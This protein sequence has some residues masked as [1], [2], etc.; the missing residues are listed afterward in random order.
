MNFNPV[1]MEKHY[2]LLSNKLRICNFC[3][4]GW[5]MLAL[6][7]L[8]GACNLL[9]SK[10]I[11]PEAAGDTLKETFI[12]NPQKIAR[13]EIKRLP[14]GSPAPDFN[15]PDIN[16][17]FLSL[18]D[19]AK[20]KVLVV[21]FTCNHCPT[22]QAYED[23]L[24][25]LTNDYKDKGVAVVAIMPNSTYGLLLEEC[26]YSDLND[27]YEEMK[28]RAE[29]KG[30]NFSY[31]YD[32][33]NQAVSIKYGPATTPHVFVFD[34]DRKLCYTGRLDGSEKPGTANAEDLRM[35]VDELLENK[36]VTNPETNTFGCSI[37]WSW[38]SEWANKVNK[39]WSE[40]PVILEEIDNNGIR[41]LLQN[42][43]GKL[44]LINFWATW[45]APCVIELPELIKLQR[46][47]GNRNFE[48]ITV[49]TDK[50]VNKEEVLKF[51]QEKESALQNYIYNKSDQY[52]LVR[53]VD[54]GWEGALPY[55][56]LV[57]PGGKVISVDQGIADI[58][59]LRKKIV[60][61]PLLG[62][63]Y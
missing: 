29:N 3:R 55:T 60:E 44:R 45:C 30:F 34:K 21:V 5:I 35:A 62:R 28:L 39:E 47:Y 27:S 12:P 48:L 38:K 14:L 6:F 51:L 24:I 53:E 17:T 54:S 40:K 59:E 31:L 18:K 19:F 26:G 20:A 57:E 56:M 58:L 46:M 16:G 42:K 50:I 33:D 36:T 8:L 49:S 1:K 43:T 63:Y 15:L 61:H 37:K 2:F 10:K 41:E 4:V 11:L 52:E 23:R 13:Q 22:A 25:R 9:H 32:G 7:F